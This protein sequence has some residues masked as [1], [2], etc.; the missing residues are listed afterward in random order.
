MRPRERRKSNRCR[1]LRTRAETV[2]VRRMDG[3]GPSRPLPAGPLSA[4][5]QAFQS[6]QIDLLTDSSLRA[7]VTPLFGARPAGTRAARLRSV[8]LSGVNLSAAALGEHRNDDG[9]LPPPPNP[10]PT[11]PPIG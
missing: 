1:P 4:R 3:D 6:G 5:P 11:D 7:N 10:Q 8:D 2:R 9:Q